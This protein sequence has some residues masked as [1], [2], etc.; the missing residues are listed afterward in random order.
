M[1]ARVFVLRKMAASLSLEDWLQEPSRGFCRANSTNLGI[2]TV[3]KMVAIFRYSSLS[4]LLL[5]DFIISACDSL[6]DRKKVHQ[7]SCLATPP[8]DTE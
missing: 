1:P 3:K 8:H 2:S 5:F 7:K 4:L 6:L